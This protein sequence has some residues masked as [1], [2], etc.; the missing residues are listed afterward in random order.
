MRR[1]EAL[2]ILHDYTKTEGLR[3]H[4]YAVEAAMRACAARFGEDPEVWGVVGLLHDF[5]YEQFPRYPDHPVKGSEILAAR[6][7]DEASRRAILGHVPA[8]NVPRE[9]GMARALFACDELCGFVMACAAVRPNKLADLEASS[10]RKKLKDKAFARAVS[11]D[12]IQQ[13][14]A[15]LQVEFADHVQMV[16]DALRPIAAEL[17]LSSDVKGE[18]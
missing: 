11:R 12:D 7:L 1:E 4:A 9:T 13:G 18:P 16:I 2:A 8:M 14:I 3:R 6:G 17:G 10:V 15:E 5:D